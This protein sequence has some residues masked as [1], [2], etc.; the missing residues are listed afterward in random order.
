MGLFEKKPTLADGLMAQGKAINKLAEAEETKAREARWAEE[1]R[2]K[3]EKKMKEMEIEAQERKMQMEVTAQKAAEFQSLGNEG[4]VDAYR[5]LFFAR[6]GEQKRKNENLY[7]NPKGLK[8]SLAEPFI[9]SKTPKSIDNL[10]D[11]EQALESFPFDRDPIEFR[12]I[13]IFLKQEAQK[14]QSFDTAQLTFISKQME[15]METAA[16]M[17]FDKPDFSSLLPEM[18]QTI[19]DIKEK[20]KGIQQKILKIIGIV[21]GAIF[22]LGILAAILS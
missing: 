6:S 21:L 9:G 14:S 1:D 17:N 4:T 7:S 3:H 16:E 19:T 18:K 22:L 12:K 20:V 5:K 10:G 8:D 15:K 11:V 2:L 13:W